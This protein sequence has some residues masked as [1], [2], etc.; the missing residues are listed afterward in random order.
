MNIPG[1]LAAK[2]ALNVAKWYWRNH[3]QGGCMHW[4]ARD[5]QDLRT[6]DER[7]LWRKTDIE[8]REAKRRKAKSGGIVNLAKLRIERAKRKKAS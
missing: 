6:D 4:R 2:N 7:R 5:L 8:L 3:L 1:F